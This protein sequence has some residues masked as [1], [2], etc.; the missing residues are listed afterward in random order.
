M[1]Q[2]SSNKTAKDVPIGSLASYKGGISTFVNEVSCFYMSTLFLCFYDRYLCCL[3]IDWEVSWKR[4]SEGIIPPYQAT[5][6]LQ[7]FY[8]TDIN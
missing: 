8:R 1:V 2:A 7:S 5:D 3:A 6:A 4:S